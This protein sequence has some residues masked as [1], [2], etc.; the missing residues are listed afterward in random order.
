MQSLS[1][2]GI[3]LL[4]EKNRESSLDNGCENVEKLRNEILDHQEQLS[5]KKRSA[6]NIDNELA[7]IQRERDELFSVSFFLV[8]KMILFLFR[9]LKLN[10]TSWLMK[11]S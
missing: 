6:A 1:E 11:R 3:K 4:D 8:I 10:K 5:A 9:F 2:K 7:K